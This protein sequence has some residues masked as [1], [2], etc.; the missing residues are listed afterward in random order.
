MDAKTETNGER[1]R[2]KNSSRKTK[3]RVGKKKN[4]YVLYNK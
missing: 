2:I 3:L 1:L 4:R